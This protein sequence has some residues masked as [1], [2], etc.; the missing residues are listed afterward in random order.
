[1]SNYKFNIN[2]YHSISNADIAI[3]GITVLS[4][5]NGCGKSTIGRWLYY[6]VNHL[7]NFE[8]DV[9]ADCIAY[10]KSKIESWDKILPSNYNKLTYSQ[11]QDT[12]DIKQYFKIWQNGFSRLLSEFLSKEKNV[13]NRQRILKYLEINA[14]ASEDGVAVSKKF[15][16]KSENEIELIYNHFEKIASNRI[17]IDFFNYLQK[18]Y[19]VSESHPENISLKEDNVEILGQTIG[20][21][22]YLQS[23]VFVDTPMF[24][25]VNGDDNLIWADVKKKIMQTSSQPKN[26]IKKISDEISDILHG[27]FIVQKNPYYGNEELKFISNNNESLDFEN[28][29]TGFK[30]FAYIQRLIETSNLNEKSLLIIDEPEAHLHPDWIFEYAR[31]LTMIYKTLGTKI[32]IATH[33]PDMVSAMQTITEKEGVLSNT[34]FYIAQKNTSGKFDYKSLSGDTEDIFKSFNVALDKIEEYAAGNRQ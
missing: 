25:S 12:T 16:N 30:T 9:E 27:R 18:K 5:I 14:G 2:N 1:M 19:V 28:V 20:N 32:V 31:I 21:L 24:L 26:Q 33:N 22:L 11:L 6:V 15:I 34:N 4:G 13:E 7:S 17:S 8:N 3:N 10:I 29:A 23:A